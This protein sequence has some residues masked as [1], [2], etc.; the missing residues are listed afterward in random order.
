MPTS[1]PATS[2]CSTTMSIGFID[3]GMVGRLDDATRKTLLYYYYSRRHERRGKRRPHPGRHG[4]PR[5]AEATPT[6][7][8]ASSPT[9]IVAGSAPPRITAC[10]SP[11][12]SCSPSA[13]PVATTSTTRKRSSSWSRPSSPSKASPTSSTPASRFISVARSYIRRIIL[14]ELSPT[15]LYRRTVISAP[16]FLDVMMRSPMIIARELQHIDQRNQ[17]ATA[18]SFTGVK[19]TIL[20]GFMLVTGAVMAAGGVIWPVWSYHDHR[21][22]H[23][24][25][26][27]EKLAPGNGSDVRP[28]T[29]PPTANG[30][31][32]EPARDGRYHAILHRNPILHCWP[33][34][35]PSSS[36]GPR[37]P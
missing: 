25:P 14:H 24:L 3:L 35:P 10:P 7:C 30:A 21:V 29:S 5:T 20:A 23:R 31:H 9:S 37:P 4:D 8:A 33:S 17:S 36:S 19:E 26:R 18:P 6:V 2:C 27:F 11:S 1:T 34:P 22:G 28:L 32:D 12:S 13:W 16:E 15:T